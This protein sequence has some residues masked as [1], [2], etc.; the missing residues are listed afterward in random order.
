MSDT[1]VIWCDTDGTLWIGPDTGVAGYRMNADGS[2]ALTMADRLAIYR[3]TD[4]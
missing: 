1:Y 3:V 2:P 4:D